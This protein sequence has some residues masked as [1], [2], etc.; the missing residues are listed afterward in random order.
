MVRL[1]GLPRTRAGCADPRGFPPPQEA[2]PS[3]TIPATSRCSTD[4]SGGDM[5]ATGRPRSV[6]VMRS[7]S[8]TLLRNSLNRFFRSRTPTFA[9]PTSLVATLY[10]C[11]GYMPSA[12]VLAAIVVGRCVSMGGGF[13]R[14]ITHHERRDPPEDRAVGA[15]LGHVGAR[16]RDRHAEL[17]HAG[18][19]RGGVPSGD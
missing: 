12:G 5:T 1:T 6:T 2:K 17:H 10:S 16:R 13:G 11:R 15:E 18:A 4:T 19:N 14:K 7:P 9:T 8:A 3:R